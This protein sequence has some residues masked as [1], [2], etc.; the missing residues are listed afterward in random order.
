MRPVEKGPWPP[1]PANPTLPKKYAPFDQAK[2]DL[3]AALGEYCSFCEWE[4]PYSSLAVEHVQAKKYRDAAGVAIYAHLSESWENFLLACRHCN[5]IKGNQNVALPGNYMPHLTN[6]WHC[7]V[8][9]PGGIVEVNPH[10]AA[11]ALAA[12]ETLMKLVGLDRRPGHPRYSPKDR[13]W[14]KRFNAWQL[15]EQYE[16]E[17]A[18]GRITV[19]TVCDLAVPRGFWSVWMTVFAAHPLVQQALVVAFQGTFAGYATAG[20]TR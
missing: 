17:Y 1:D 7:F 14:E 5:S 16:P 12:A 18:A 11:P 15:A 20:L 4:Q 9:G 3:I 10:L 2:D 19:Q 8:L 6:T 13:R